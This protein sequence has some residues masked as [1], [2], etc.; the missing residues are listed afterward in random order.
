MTIL[1]K[2]NNVDFL[3]LTNI[4]YKL[5]NIL[6]HQRNINFYFDLSRYMLRSHWIIM[7]YLRQLLYYNIT[8]LIHITRKIT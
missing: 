3:F 5:T 4:A 1:V 6:V 2:Q 8:F 7:C